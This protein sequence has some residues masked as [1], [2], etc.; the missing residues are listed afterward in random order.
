[1]KQGPLHL[2]L[3]PNDR[4]TCSECGKLLFNTVAFLRGRTVQDHYGNIKY[5]VGVVLCVT[6]EP[7]TRASEREATHDDE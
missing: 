6:C 4:L 2:I 1:M 3:D 5:K 7:I